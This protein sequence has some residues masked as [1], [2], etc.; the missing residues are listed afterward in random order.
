[1]LVHQIQPNNQ[2]T[3]QIETQSKR[4]I[5]LHVKLF[6]IQWAFLFATSIFAYFF[7]GELIQ[8]IIFLEL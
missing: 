8:G 7:I 6:F 3:L 2:F 1:M 5:K 4:K